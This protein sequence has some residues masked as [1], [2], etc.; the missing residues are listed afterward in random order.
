MFLQL[1]LKYNPSLWKIY[2]VTYIVTLGVYFSIEKNTY[3]IYLLYNTYMY[4]YI[5]FA[6]YFFLFI[7]F[8][9]TYIK[10]IYFLGR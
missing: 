8:S 4:V 3:I 10:I 1:F 7:C 6:K 9:T 2:N 5:L